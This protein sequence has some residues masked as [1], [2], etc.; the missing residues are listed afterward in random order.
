MIS[1]TELTREDIGRPV[2]AQAGD[3]GAWYSG[4]LAGWTATHLIVKFD[5]RTALRLTLYSKFADFTPDKVR[6]ARDSARAEALL[7]R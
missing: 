7:T 6:F 1:I 5:R 4:G 3:A 2:Q